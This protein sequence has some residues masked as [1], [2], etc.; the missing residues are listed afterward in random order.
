MNLEKAFE[1]KFKKQNIF[2]FSTKII[3]F[4][5]LYTLFILLYY[6]IKKLLDY[7]EQCNKMYINVARNVA[8]RQSFGSGLNK[9]GSGFSQ[10]LDPDPVLV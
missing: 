2:P 8:Y 1:T 3:K 4:A 10:V 5:V 9:V 7:S 6:P